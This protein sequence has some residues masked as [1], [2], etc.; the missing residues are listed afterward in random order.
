MIQEE[1]LIFL[2]SIILYF[3]LCICIQCHK[4]ALHK[5]RCSFRSITSKPEE[6][7][8]DMGKKS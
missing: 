3:I 8:D 4:V 7:G 6:T 1:R 2:F 5:P